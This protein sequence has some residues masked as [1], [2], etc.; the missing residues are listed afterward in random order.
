[1][2]EEAD[3]KEVYGYTS[4]YKITVRHQ[5]VTTS[6][7]GNNTLKCT[8]DSIFGRYGKVLLS[9]YMYTSVSSLFKKDELSMI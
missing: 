5:C 6:K 1:M 9:F 8:N 3:M 2:V 4:Y 7:L